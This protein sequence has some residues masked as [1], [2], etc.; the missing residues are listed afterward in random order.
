MTKLLNLDEITETTEK[1]VKIKGK[2]YPVVERTVGQVLSA[3]KMEKKLA[4]S[5]DELAQFE[6]YVSLVAEAI[7]DCPREE[8]M[9]M[10]MKSLGAIMNY[11]NEAEEVTEEA[12]GG[13]QGK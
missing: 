12:E 3:I 4:K 2:E 9:R 6:A 1:F 13:E 8:L 10:P 7:P 5:N 11:V